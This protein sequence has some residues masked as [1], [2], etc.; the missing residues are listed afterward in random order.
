[1]ALRTVLLLLEQM[2][3]RAFLVSRFSFIFLLNFLRWLLEGHPQLGGQVLRQRAGQA[4]LFGGLGGLDELLGHRDADL[5]RLEV[6]VD[7]VQEQPSDCL[8]TL[9]GILGSIG[10]GDL[11]QAVTD[12]ISRSLK[13]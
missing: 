13:P 1:M 3:Q 11:G 9:F 7:A 4:V 10:S 8:P 2:R 12:F 5:V 6:S